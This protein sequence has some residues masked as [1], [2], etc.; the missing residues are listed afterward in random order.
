MTGARAL[1]LG[2]ST[3]AGAS[4]TGAWG[5]GLGARGRTTSVVAR[6]FFLERSVKATE[7]AANLVA[8]GLKIRTI[9]QRQK[10]EPRGQLDA[11]LEFTM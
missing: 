4:R 7:Q 9:F 11:G 3:G 6:D 2:L 10:A 8:Q 1:G 5:W